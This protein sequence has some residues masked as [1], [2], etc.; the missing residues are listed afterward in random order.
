MKH[1]PCQLLS[2]AACPRVILSPPLRSPSSLKRRWKRQQRP[3]Q[4]TCAQSLSRVRLCDPVGCSLPGSSVHGILQVRR[5][6]QLDVPSSR[7]SSQPGDQTQVPTLQVDSLP[8]EQP[9]KPLAMHTSW[10]M[11]LLAAL[12]AL[13][14]TP[15]YWHP[16]WDVPELFW[17]WT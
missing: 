7:G 11:S 3:Q 15:V 4:C 1:V 5:L 16:F 9:G 8:T 6:E 10:K 17:A 2:L 13:S 14:L 12:I